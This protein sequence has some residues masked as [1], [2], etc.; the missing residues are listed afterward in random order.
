MR[1]LHTMVGHAALICLAAAADSGAEDKPISAPLDGQIA[2]TAH[3]NGDGTW[4]VKR[5][6]DGPILKDG[7]AREK[8]LAIVGGATGP[9]EPQNDQEAEAAKQRAAIEMKEAKREERDL[10]APDADASLAELLD[11]QSMKAAHDAAV[12]RAEKAETDLAEARDDLDKAEKAAADQTEAHNALKAAH[13][14]GV[15]N[16]KK[17]D[18]ENKDLRREIASKDEDIRQLREQIA[19]FDGDGNGKVGGGTSK[20]GAD[21]V[22]KTAGEGP[23]KA[24]NG[25]A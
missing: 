1:L 13:D 17:T 21:L 9:Y 24:K 3:N 25:D 5:G 16:A 7:L 6:P 8:A 19:K 18:D 15:A 20:A 10:F 4:S 12:D 11:G 14:E 22:S 23:S 2:L